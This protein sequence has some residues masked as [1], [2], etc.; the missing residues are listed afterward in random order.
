MDG[1]HYYAIAEGHVAGVPALVARTGYTGEDGFE[2][3]VDV[4]DA[5]ADLGRAHGGRRGR[6]P[7]AG[8]PRAPATPSDSKPGCRYTATS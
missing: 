8:R 5:A 7:R 2:I 3:F 4:A 1:L 6:G